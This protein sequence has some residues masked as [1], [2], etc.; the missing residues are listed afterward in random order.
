MAFKR[1]PPI[2]TPSQAVYQRLPYATLARSS[3]YFHYALL[4]F[5][6]GV[7][8]AFL[9]SASTNLVVLFLPAFIAA[10]IPALLYLYW[11]K[12]VDRYEPEPM[13][14]IA[15]A[16]G[17]GAASTILAIIPNEILIPLLGGWMGTAAFVEEPLKILG[18]YLISASPWLRGELNDHLDGLL[19]G[20]AAGL[21][22]GFIENI[23]YIARGLALGAPLIIP[24]RVLTMGMHMFCSGLIGWWMGYLKVNAIEIRWSTI[25][26]ALIT[27]I[28]VHATWNTMGSLGVVGLL[29]LLVM[30]PY[31]VFRVHRM[32]MDALVDEYYWGFAH[33]YAPVETV[34]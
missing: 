12:R 32:A 19:Y 22:F 24:L 30:G 33:G 23:L 8:L 2:F 9:V 27:A 34:S 4:A 15:L 16:F 29:I 26:P 1:R 7:A 11:I 6:S 17:W 3:R 13:W 25:T 21:G 14:L 31:L 18:V 10:L 20:A 5:I 28:V